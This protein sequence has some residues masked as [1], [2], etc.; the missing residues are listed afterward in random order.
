VS[1]IDIA[2]PRRLERR[3][4]GRQFCV[5]RRE[6]ETRMVSIVVVQCDTTRDHPGRA[7][8]KKRN[9][10]EARMPTTTRELV[11]VVAGDAAEE[12]GKLLI[13]IAEEM[14]CER[15]GEH[16]DPERA[17]GLRQ[18]DCIPGW[19]DAALRVEANETAGLRVAGT[20][21][22]DEHRAIEARHQ[23]IEVVFRAHFR[24]PSEL[25]VVGAD[26]ETVLDVALLDLRHLFVR[27][28]LDAHEVVIGSR[29]R[30]D[31]LVQLELRRSLLPALRVLDRE[32]HDGRHRRARRR[33]RRL[34][35]QRKSG[36]REGNAEHE[37]EHGGHYCGGRMR[38][39]PVDLLYGPTERVRAS[40]IHRL[41]CNTRQRRARNGRSRLRRVQVRAACY[42]RSMASL[43]P[44]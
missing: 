22:D 23:S 15:I 5:V 24:T 25:L 14:Q 30:L 2:D 36:D 41:C 33:E 21:R 8:V 42:I 12:L 19:F 17:V 9:A 10:V 35:T 7:R 39:R 27:T 6:D 29:Q 43:R 16:S 38:R 18:P 20:R 28:R 13:A 26:G 4:L 1:R 11:V 31:Q 34:P 40:P 32:D 3:E 44:F 37:H